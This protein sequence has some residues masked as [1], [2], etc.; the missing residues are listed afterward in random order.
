MWSER[1]LFKI[2]K[3]TAEKKVILDK[4]LSLFKLNDQFMPMSKIGAPIIASQGAA[5]DI[6]DLIP[7]KQEDQLISQ[8]YIFF[9]DR[10]KSKPEFPLISAFQTF[11]G[12]KRPLIDIR[13]ESGL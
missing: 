12:K 6:V 10:D 2:N 4:K 8:P 1:L 13:G 9:I 11:D 3:R 7:K 5:L